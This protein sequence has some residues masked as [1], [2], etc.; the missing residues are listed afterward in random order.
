MQ[1]IANRGHGSLSPT[2]RTGS[3]MNPSPGGSNLK[4]MKD[5]SRVLNNS[6]ST[7]V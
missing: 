5:A 6:S 2:D 7:A 1:G 3:Q 4:H